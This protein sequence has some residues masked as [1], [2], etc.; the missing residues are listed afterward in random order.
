MS[1]HE[2]SQS[3]P[4]NSLQNTRWSSYWCQGLI[5]STALAVKVKTQRR[6]I[7]PSSCK[8]VIPLSLKRHL[9]QLKVVR[10]F[11]SLAE[12]QSELQY[13]KSELTLSIVYLLL[14]LL[15]YTNQMFHHSVA[16][17]MMVLAQQDS[18]SLL[19][20]S[21]TQL[22]TLTFGKQMLLNTKL[23][24]NILKTPFHPNISM[25]ILHT[26]LYTFL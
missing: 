24:C 13:S 7:E 16:L 20:Y 9:N 8:P 2:S 6:I 4:G 26:V 11:N 17:C 5:E 23:R 14:P 10:R 18:L 19:C 15:H 1:L 3:I 25:H 12:G 22:Y 21:L